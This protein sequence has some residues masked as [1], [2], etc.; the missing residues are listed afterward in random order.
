MAVQWK[1]VIRLTDTLFAVS[2]HSNPDGKDR[3]GFCNVG[4]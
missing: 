1:L 2:H 4:F 3:T